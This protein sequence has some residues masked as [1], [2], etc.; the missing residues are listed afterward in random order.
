METDLTQLAQLTL[1][2]T[3]TD[4]P[5]RFSLHIKFDLTTKHTLEIQE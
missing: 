4:F 5:A 3:K 1:E 2:N